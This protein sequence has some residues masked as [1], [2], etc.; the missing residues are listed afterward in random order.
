MNDVYEAIERLSAEL[1][2]RIGRLAGERGWGYKPYSW[3]IARD[4]ERFFMIVATTV[5]LPGGRYASFSPQAE[6]MGTSW[7]ID[8]RRTDGAERE[9]WARGLTVMKSGNGFALY[10][11]SGAVSDDALAA[12]VTDLGEFP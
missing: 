12:I 2:S 1:S 9:L 6:P 3:M 7:R 8:V 5:S 10:D 11:G 4:D